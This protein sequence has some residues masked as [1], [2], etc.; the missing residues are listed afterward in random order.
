MQIIDEKQPLE[1]GA[2][3]RF[4]FGIKAPLIPIGDLNAKR[5][6]LALRI[7]E[8]LIDK[9][10][11][12]VHTYVYTTSIY[13]IGTYKP[14]LEATRQTGSLTQS[15]LNNGY[16]I[17]VFPLVLVGT[18]VVALSILVVA[19][20]FYIVSKNVEKV[21]NPKVNYWILGTFVFV[22]IVVFILFNKRK[23]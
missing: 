20:A 22:V 10:F 5:E 8:T 2:L 18:I 13:A 6:A 9:G 7:K 3:Y 23:L 11:I 1:F 14:Q 19:F 17:A 4:N 21:T 15:F 12:D 16:E